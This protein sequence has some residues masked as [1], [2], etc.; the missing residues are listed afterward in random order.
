[1]YILI[2]VF[3]FIERRTAHVKYIVK[4][5]RNPLCSRIS[6]F[7]TDGFQWENVVHRRWLVARDYT[8]KLKPADL[9]TVRLPIIAQELDALA[10]FVSSNVS[11][12]KLNSMPA[13]KDAGYA[14]RRPKEKLEE[15][16]S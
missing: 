8:R 4:V 6:Y 13:T 12:A 15:A 3:Y 5:T 16:S 14:W 11:R 7:I 1:M 10:R 9:C 2:Y